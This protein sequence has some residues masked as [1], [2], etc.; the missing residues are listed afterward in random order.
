MS[1]DEQL[2]TAYKQA[3]QDPCANLDKLSRL[4]PVLGEDGEPY[5]IDGSK[6][7][8]CGEELIYEINE[9]TERRDKYKILRPDVWKQF[10]INIKKT[11]RFTVFSNQN[12]LTLDE[13]ERVFLAFKKMYPNL[14]TIIPNFVHNWPGIEK[15]AM[16]AYWL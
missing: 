2:K 4:T 8:T 13:T 5:C 1:M 7:L 9:F 6:T 12:D 10:K 3:I 14:K 11:L 16:K 15:G